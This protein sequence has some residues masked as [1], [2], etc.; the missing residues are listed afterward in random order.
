MPLVDYKVYRQEILNFLQSCT[1]KFDLFAEN[2]LLELEKNGIDINDVVAKY[3]KKRITVPTEDDKNNL[4]YNDVKKGYYVKVISTGNIYKV[5]N[6]SIVNIE[7]EKYTNEDKNEIFKKIS[8]DD[9]NPYY[10]NLAGEYSILDNTKD[11]FDEDIV[12][13]G[14]NGED[15]RIYINVIETKENNVLLTKELLS[16]Y[17]M[18]ASVYKIGNP[19]YEQLL[20]KY[21][22]KHG[23]IK[24]ICYPVESYE[25]AKNSRDL[26]LLKYDASFLEAEERDS[27]ILALKKFLEYVYNRWFVYDFKFE[28][29]Y[30]IT[31]MGM[32][33]STL[34]SVL[35]TERIKNLRTSQV[36]SMHIWEY[37]D[38]KGLG[39]YKP[40]LN[41][42]QSVFLYR[43]IDYLIQNKGKKT[44]IEILA[45]NLL[46]GLHIHLVGKTI[47]Q[48]TSTNY[49][50]CITN[51]EFLSDTVV[52]RGTTEQINE[53]SK[54]DMRQI[55]YRMYTEGYYPDYS[56]DNSVEMNE[57]F[58]LTEFNNLP[59]R[60]LEFEKNI[61]DNK[62]IS[63]FTEFMMD[64]LVYHWTKGIPIFNINFVD[65]VSLT[66]LDLNVGETLAL[67]H[68]IHFKE[69]GITPINIPTFY[70]SRL[71][72]P[73]LKPNNLPDSYYFEDLTPK[74][75]KKN[76]I[77][78]F[79]Y[80]LKGFINTD[81]I[82]KDIPF[83]I[84][85]TGSQV[86]YMTK[87]AYH[88]KALL[89][90]TRQ[91]R[92]SAHTRY[93]EAMKYY[94]EHLVLHDVL[95]YNKYNSDEEIETT[96]I[97]GEEFIDFD[98]PHKCIPKRLEIKLTKYDTYSDWIKNKENLSYI[99]DMYDKTD[100][101]KEYYKQL[102]DTL[103]MK[104]FPIEEMPIFDEFT[105]ADKDNSEIYKG[106][107]K[108]FIQL[109][110]YRLFFLETD[111][112]PLN[113]IV[114][115]Y[116]SLYTLEGSDSSELIAPFGINVKT[117][118]VEE[119]NTK[120]INKIIPN[121]YINTDQPFE[122]NL[123][124]INL[125]TDEYYHV[126][127]IYHNEVYPIINNQIIYK[128]EKWFSPLDLYDIYRVLF[129]AY[130]DSDGSA[131]MPIDNNDYY[132]K[133]LE[134]RSGYLVALKRDAMSTIIENHPDIFTSLD[135]F[136][137]TISYDNN[138]ILNTKLLDDEFTE[139]HNTSI[140]IG[141]NK[142][143]IDE[144]K[145]KTTINII[146]GS[147][148]AEI[149]DHVVDKSITD[150]PC[151]TNGVELSPINF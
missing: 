34:P 102:C 60:L 91:V 136:K 87:L 28:P 70:T 132:V 122:Y 140:S 33:W 49:E 1:I 48:E 141:I 134:D 109:C 98:L 40:I 85:T 54:Q 78:C 120:F 125:P 46:K 73:L 36:H 151:G 47:L 86:E 143:N 81:Q 43:N 103:W 150:L 138:D 142:E 99:L 135:Q 38:S 24:S 95:I 139:L 118:I 62:Y 89:K 147:T 105:G 22:K 101:P 10:L 90:H 127:I 69:A 94:Y 75:N 67:L 72:Y 93:Q 55:L 112:T 80:K 30:A 39:E 19:E 71:A 146:P 123:T 111:R 116:Q 148:L 26:S 25:I 108:L 131:Y 77:S 96:F 27:L 51:P 119:F 126:F 42:D 35:L 107:K 124:T 16:K 9:I 61:L 2:A 79:K 12:L 32:I 64:S 149:S 50:D 8:V 97:N 14:D 41:R 117:H 4:T 3:N 83:D 121:L 92:E 63:Y 45:E 84:I 11:N 68:Y 100:N 144:F 88:F 145:D 53:D 17:P 44:N 82:L 58:G 59:T 31:F 57:K 106:L 20:K 76:N 104:L 137:I 114:S 113:Y 129:S 18:T 37:L 52:Q 6:V 65:T 29:A 115:P 128:N 15:N 13:R 7:F 56:V 74:Y 23:L 133:A 66:T 130:I 5:I 21:P 110:S